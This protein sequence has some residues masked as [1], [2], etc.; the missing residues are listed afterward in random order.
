[1]SISQND[2]YK[3]IYAATLWNFWCG[4]QPWHGA[5]HIQNIAQEL[6]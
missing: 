5:Q 6:V 1:L 3:K 2:F 4:D